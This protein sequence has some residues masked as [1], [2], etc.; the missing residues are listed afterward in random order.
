MATIKP[1]GNSFNVI[2]HYKGGDGKNVQQWEAYKTELEA[3]HRKAHV[4]YVQKTK[5]HD[6]LRQLALEYKQ[7]R[8]TLTP[9]PSAQTAPAE[10]LKRED[11]EAKTLA[12]FAVKWLPIHAGKKQLSP[13]SFDGINNNLRA[14]ILPYFG[15]RIMSS[16]TAEDIDEFLEHLRQK[17]CQGAKSFNKRPE[18]IPT[19]SSGTV[20]KNYD[21]LASMFPVAKEWG[22][23]TENPVT[24]APSVR[25]K[26]RKFWVREQIQDALNRIDD[27]LLH[28]AVHITFMCSLRSGEALGLEIRSIDFKEGSLWIT[29]TIQRVSDE[30]L[31]KIP[32]DEILRIFPKKKAYAT[33]QLILKT[34]KTE[35]SERKLFLNAH[36]LEEISRM[37]HQIE[38][39]KAFFG[40]EY[41]DYGLLLAQPNGD[42][43]ETT[44]LEKWFRDWQVSSHRDPVI[45]I[46]G[47]RKSSSM[48]KLRL[49]GFNYQ[50]VQGDT[51][52]TSPT[53]L[54]GH[55]NEALE[56]ERKNLT[57]K[58][59]DDFYPKP[60]SSHAGEMTPDDTLEKLL[61]EVMV[62]PRLLDRLAQAMQKM[63]AVQ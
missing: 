43:I 23:T 2:Y 63:Q 62:N 59:Q 27:P 18:D 31:N 35:D 56:F 20:K 9:K 19:L 48:Y 22:Y 36:L 12:E 30:A 51:G 57:I 58:I 52:H 4:D 28:L 46:Q 14:H 5:D 54:M 42:P 50:E 7:A 10:Q 37:I 17:K 3:I 55:Y 40:D 61:E 16:I 24:K 53:V 33:S 45:D 60:V 49:S 11:N 38:K 1:R 29:Q 41:H 8:E 47:L 34:P 26:K 13:Y 44:R 21:V 25:Y 15:N 6:A 32:R 39:N